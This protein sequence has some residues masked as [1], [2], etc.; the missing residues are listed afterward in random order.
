MNQLTILGDFNCPF[1]ASTLVLRDGC[2]SRGLGALA[3]LAALAEEIP[4]P[5]HEEVAVNET[6]AM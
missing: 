4:D 5:G 2:I 3:Y 6:N 1:S